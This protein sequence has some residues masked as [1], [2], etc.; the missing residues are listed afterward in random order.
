[1]T[2]GLRVSIARGALSNSLAAWLNC[3]TAP[4]ALSTG[5]PAEA[6]ANRRSYCAFSARIFSWRAASSLVLDLQLGLVETQLVEGLVT[7]ERRISGFDPGK[8]IEPFSS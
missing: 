2:R 7:P 1:M 3:K 8:Y 4:C 5:M 6:V